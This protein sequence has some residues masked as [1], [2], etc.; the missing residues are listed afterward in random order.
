[1]S[2]SAL[3]LLTLCVALPAS[4]E[5]LRHNLFDTLTDLRSSVE[6][7]YRVLQLDGA[8]MLAEVGQPQLPVRRFDFVVP[9]GFRVGRVSVEGAERLRAG[10]ATGLRI[11]EPWISGEGKPSI[12]LMPARDAGGIWPAQDA[13]IVSDQFLHGFRMVTVE[14]RPV[15]VEPDGSLVMTVGGQ[16]VL[17]LEADLSDGSVARRKRDV[18]V[19]K[20]RVHEQ[21]RSRVV[22]PGDLDRAGGP[23]TVSP[24][25]E[26]YIQPGIAPSLDSSPVQHLI[27][28][29]D[30]LRDEFQRLADHRIA[31]GLPSVVV[32]LTEVLTNARQGVDKAETVRNYVREAYELWGVDYLLIGGDTEILPVRYAHSTFYPA[33]S[34]TDIPTD[35]Y[36]AC[37]D[38]D[39][40]ADGDG[41]FGE[42]FRNAVDTGDFTDLEAELA[43]GRAPVRDL[44]QAS[45]FVDKVIEYETPLTTDWQDQTLLAAEVL[46]PSDWSS[47]ADPITVDGAA[48]TEALLDS[49]FDPCVDPSITVTR[50]YQ[51][52]TAYPGS[53]EETAAGVFS[54]LN[55]GDYGVFGHTGH[56][57]YFTMSMGNGQIEV[58]DADALQN[59]PNWFVLYSL[60]CSSSAFDFAC[61]NERFLTN[62]NGG[63]VISV[64]SSRAAF[65]TA[66][67]AFQEE[68]YRAW[69]CGGVER[70]GDVFNA[71]REPFVANTFYNTIE[72][73]TQFVYC[74]LGDPAT[75]LWSKTPQRVAFSNPP[76]MSLGDE[77]VSLTVLASSGSPDPVEGVVVTARKG[78]ED[79]AVGVTDALGQVTLEFQPET[80]GVVEVWASGASVVP[81]N[82]ALDVLDA[83]GAVVSVTATTLRD[84]GGGGSSGNGNGSAEAGEIVAL[85]PTFVNGGLAGLAGGGAATLRSLDPWIAVIDSV[86]SIPAL[87]AGA[88][89]PATS[90]WTLTVHPDAPDGYNTVLEVLLDAPVGP[91]RVDHV[92]FGL[93]APDAEIFALV[94]DDALG[95]D[96]GIADNGEVVNLAFTLRNYGDGVASGLSATLSIIAGSGVVIDPSGS[97][98]DLGSPLASADNSAD[99]FTVQVQDVPASILLQLSLTDA[100]GR[101]HVREFDLVPPTSSDNIFLAEGRPDRLR[102]AWNPAPDADRMGY[103]LYRKGPGDVDFLLDSP[104]IL[105]S[106]ATFESTDLL[107]LSD[108]EFY[109][110]TVDS[111]GLRSAPSGTFVTSTYPPEVA[112]FPVRIGL[113]TSS[114][115]AVGTIDQ[116]F[117]P[118]LVV[119]SDFVYAIDANC[120]EKQDGDGDS[121]TLGPI[122]AIRGQYQPGGLALGELFL[123]DLGQ[124]IVILDRDTRSLYVL[125]DEGNPMPGWPKVLLNWAWSTPAIGDVDGDGDLEIVVNDIGGYTYA[126]HHDGTEVADGDANAATY[127]V[128][129]PRRQQDVGGT[130]YTEWFG[131]SSPALF[132]VDGDGAREILFGSKYQNGSAPEFFYALNADGSGT[133]A[134]GW[135][136]TLVPRSE[137]LASPTVADL[138]GDGIYE[139]I[140]VSENDSLYVWDELGNI[141]AGF[142]ISRPQDSVQQN[143]VTPSPAVGDFDEDG[144]LE[145]VFVSVEK[146]G[147]K[148]WVSNVEIISADGT[149][150]P[151]WPVS[152]PDMSESSPVI[153]DMNGDGSL[154]IAYG[155]GGIEAD[156]A[157]YAW[158]VN[159]DALPGFPIPIEGFVRATPTI[160][161]FN[162]DGNVNLLSASWDAQIHVWDLLAPYD[163]TRAPWPTFR[164]NVNRTGVYDEFV[165]TSAPDALPLSR[166]QLGQAR[167]NPFNP[168]TEISFELGA[169]SSD[170][171]LVLYDA[172]GRRV[173]GLTA[174]DYPA[175]R[176]QVDWDGTDEQGR[177][178]ASGVYFARLAVDGV[179]SGVR[180]LALVK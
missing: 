159:G 123:D 63:S 87:G 113:E 139:I 97:W 17:E 38:G 69:Y 54:A 100:Y 120:T 166:N 67:S 108:Y 22:N 60:N 2:W 172:R 104:D 41:F 94:V 118:E 59:G 43:V 66:A 153:A 174:G 53:V 25:V 92:P 33:G 103:L 64:G 131:R 146:L 72:R 5:E 89:L 61:L 110:V 40:N 135:P 128:I 47:P 106:A 171:Q 32:T 132:D 80:A 116:D 62:P 42:H 36:Y 109:V 133:N 105:T 148:N 28:T 55:A 45:T 50:H 147:T 31:T 34:A 130:I 119:G 124:E 3:I 98:P 156:D 170:V 77:Q 78:F 19:W 46:F 74:L 154:D 44:A 1:V 112:C 95:N 58:A 169:P 20:D 14:F 158:D 84:D 35:H 152:A 73:W 115:L 56:G 68:F 179:E 99:P 11:S 177:P 143:S 70:V 30:E 57:F 180:K 138:E 126:F 127:G 81:T 82:V 157:M 91:D 16:L 144:T 13:A 8:D 65:P 129:A 151:G 117:T 6:D 149:T 137:F 141:R 176:H 76:D 51:N 90:G 37:L 178:V 164:G 29:T 121:Q 23:L 88:S 122:N 155:I 12:A 7:G 102:V 125:N 107:P 75:R 150:W 79:Y 175:G 162:G 26:Q 173:R 83:A 136:K 39:W 165:K 111:A 167:P 85:T 21:I 96:D 71:S 134:P 4:A 145:I 9:A 114:S 49:V 101:S 168:R 93:A 140:A 160:I 86:V 27:I 48:L 52:Y 163:E 15:R 161:D 24:T 18:P 10:D 142:P